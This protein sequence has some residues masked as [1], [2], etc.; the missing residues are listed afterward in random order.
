MRVQRATLKH[1]VRLDD[2]PKNR[3]SHHV[4]TCAMCMRSGETKKIFPARPE[5]C[6]SKDINR[7]R[8]KEI[9]Y[10]TPMK[11]YESSH[12]IFNEVIPPSLDV[13]VMQ[14]QSSM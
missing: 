12:H 11:F 9:T 8:G 6:D 1:V 13:L 5:I 3:I 10:I 2:W 7:P 4:L 14:C